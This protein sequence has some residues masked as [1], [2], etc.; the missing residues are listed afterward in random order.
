MSEIGYSP[1]DDPDV[2]CDEFN[3]VLDERTLKLRFQLSSKFPFSGMAIF[4]SSCI[5]LELIVSSPGPDQW[6]HVFDSD[7]P[8]EPGTTPR[9]PAIPLRERG[10]I[11]FSVP[12]VFTR[13]VYICNSVD[14]ATLKP[15]DADLMAS[16]KISCP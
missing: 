11:S 15:R 9:I 2:T 7:V 14:H 8:V 16:V 4:K 10:I 6:I 1:Y 12:W 3:I 13:G 5:L